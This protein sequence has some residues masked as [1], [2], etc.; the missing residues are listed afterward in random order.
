MLELS[1]K[2][3]E[4]GVI[5]VTP[6]SFQYHKEFG[7]IFINGFAETL[8]GSKALVFTVKG[9]KIPYVAGI[10]KVYPLIRK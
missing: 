10:D 3:I 9:N 6:L 1:G 4:Y 8:T 7:E 5:E 2:K